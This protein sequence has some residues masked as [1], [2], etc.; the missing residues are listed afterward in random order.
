MQASH[1]R[2]SANFT[3]SSIFKKSLLCTAILCAVGVVQA[4]EIESKESQD[5][6]E[7]SEVIIITGIRESLANNLTRKRNANAVIEV[8]T[9]EDIGKFPD[10]NI[11][12]SLQR[13]P[14]VVISR[15]GGEGSTV[16]IRG[17]SSDLTFTQLNGNFIASSPGE[18]SRSFDFVL[19]PSAMIERVEVYKSSEAR[20]DEGGVGG[21][22]LLHSRKPLNM[23]A[24]SG[25]FTFEETYSDVTDKFEP[26]FTGVYSWK[27]D[28]ENLGFLVGYTEQSRINRTLSGS[29]NTWRWTGDAASSADTNGNLVDNDLTNAAVVTA[30]GNIYDNHWVPQFTRV[31]VFEEKRKRQ[32][33]QFTGQWRPN[34]RWELGMNY[35]NFRLGLDST[36]S[37]IDMPEWNLTTGNA[38]NVTTDSSGSI[39]TGI[40]Y[41]VGA[42]G[43][44]QLVD[45]PWVRGVFNR[46]ESTSDTFDFNANYEG[47]DFSLKFVLGHTE[48]KGGPTERYEAAYYSSNNRSGEPDVENAAQFAGWAINNNRMNMYIDPN[49]LTNLFADIGGGADPGS[50]NSSFVN[51]EIEEDYFQVD[52]D[53]D[54]NFSIFSKIRAG[55]KYRNA[56]LHR[57]TSNTFYLSPDFDIAAG[58][59]RPGG[60]TRDDSYQWNNGMPDASLILNTTGMGNIAGGFN[61]NLMPTINWNA[62]ANYLADNFVRYT[63]NEDNFIYDIQEVVNAG[64]VQA[65]FTTDE[66][67]GNFGVRVVKTETTGASTDLFTFFKDEFDD[68]GNQLT[69]DERF[70]E[71]FVLVAQKSSNTI[72]LPSF[73][74]AWDYH[75]DV[76]IRAVIAKVISRPGYGSLGS[77][78]RIAWFSNEFAADRAEFNQQ[79][80]WFGSGG[81]KNLK[82]FEAIQADIGVEYYYGSGSAVGVALFN[83]DIDNFVVP[84]ILDTTRNIPVRNFNIAGLPVSAGGESVTIQNYSTV[85]N[86]T[87]ATSK[88]VEV[89]VQ[90]AF[91]SGFGIS[92]NYTYNDTNK[93][94]V[95]LDGVKVGESGLIGSA[96]FQF[97]FSTYFENEIFSVRASYNLRGDTLLG[98]SNGMNVWADEYDQIDLNASYSLSESLVITA[99]VI[100]LSKSESFNFVGD[101]TEARY[102][103]NS[104]TGRRIYAGISYSF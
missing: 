45:F 103:S 47:D 19:M 94:D 30:N 24:N 101:D 4:Q 16:S 96:K 32:G 51:S 18:P 52:F 20:L 3:L 63:R 76:V 28:Q 2:N 44:E 54:V 12:D 72:V 82:P 37:A 91:D 35:F 75:E 13:V 26:Q 73:N 69:G 79:P 83:K 23:E 59:A 29:A 61:I 7:K 34:D 65:D 93:A 89:F 5:D 43:V 50:S 85:G 11:A 80:G 1:R 15:S 99:S 66:L 98:L 58:E 40:D 36:L 84:L 102:Q 62:Y 41:T 22:I 78:E 95:S 8:I 77:Q 86:G 60:I 90:H 56:K 6:K 42:T 21:T 17:L 38:T 97:N 49:M 70:E 67:R 53:G 31:S 57:Q 25:V 100:N 27:N 48:A 104:Y 33:F 74:I 88:G 14:G 81:N 10:K 64:Y 39:I 71:E 55:L 92:S 87:N 9:A 68:D 46:E